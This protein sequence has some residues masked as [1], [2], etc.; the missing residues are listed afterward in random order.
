MPKSRYKFYYNHLV[1][2]TL[3]LSRDLQTIMQIPQLQGAI[4]TASSSRTA[5]N[6]TSAVPQ[7]TNAASLFSTSTTSGSQSTVLTKGA[8]EV[9]TGQ[10]AKITRG[11]KS[12]ATFN[13]RKG[14][15]V[16]CMV[17]L[18]RLRFYLFLDQIVTFILPNSEHFS[19][20]KSTLINSRGAYAFGLNNFLEF[21]Q[22]EPFFPQ[23]ENTKGLNIN[24]MVNLKKSK[25]SSLAN[26][27]FRNLL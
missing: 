2:E 6:Q 10:R 16:G 17:T 18:R 23:F 27:F 15:V 25:T 20:K 11:K 5:A 3:I 9:I 22:M 24:I 13:L 14:G 12:I 21:P 4:C 19:L 26:N 7:N 8:L 1:C